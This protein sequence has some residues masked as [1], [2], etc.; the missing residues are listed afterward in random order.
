MALTKVDAQLLN[1][2][3]TADS[4]GNVQ[5]STAGTS[6]L[7]S[8][9]RK[10]LNQ[11]GSILQTVHGTLVGTGSGPITSTTSTS[12]VSTGL[13]ASITPSSTSS[14]ILVMYNLGNIYNTANG[15]EGFVTIYRNGSNL[16]PIGTG[17]TSGFT[18]SFGNGAGVEA[19][20]SMI[21]LDSPASTSAQTYT[22]YWATNTGTMY[23]G[24]NA[25]IC[26]ITLLEIAQ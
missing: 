10:I 3:V 23:L 14:K 5:L 17:T 8:S 6:I 1:G 18:S 16:S 21:Y 26:T 7:N 15:L 13:T 19:P 11:T 20:H 12:W 22:V 9:G 2:A 24:R 4:S 25:P